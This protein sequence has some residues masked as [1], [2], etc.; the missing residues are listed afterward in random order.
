MT[1]KR[2][3][4]SI[5]AAVLVVAA[6][7]AGV[8]LYQNNDTSSDG[9]ASATQTASDTQMLNQ[10]AVSRGRYVAIMSDCVACHTALGSNQPF[11]GGYPIQTP[12][13]TIVSSNITPDKDTGIGNWTE[14]QFFDAVRH[15]QSP[16]GYLYPAMPYT[17]Y[18]KLT[19]QDMQDLW[20]YMRSVRPVHNQVAPNQ[21]PFPYNIRLMML[22]WNLLFF[23][24][25]PFKVDPTQSAQ[26]VRGQY[27]VD[28]AEHCI[29]C[30]TSKNMLGGDIQS[31]YLQGDELQGWYAPE[32]AGNDH[33]GLGGWSTQGIV[34]YLK[35]GSN[36]VS[37]ASGPMAEVVHNSTQYLN[38]K[39]LNAIAVYLKSVKGSATPAR[40]RSDDQTVAAMMGWGQH[41]FEAN[42]SACHNV[43]GQGVPGMVTAFA[44]NPSVQ[45]N[46][47][48]SL[49]QTV[50]AGG[51]A[52]ITDTNPT[53]AGMPSFAWKMSDHDIAAV[54]TYVRNSWGNQAPAVTDQQVADTRKS[55]KAPTPFTQAAR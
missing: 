53:G 16:H 19:D 46:N 50:L 4:L 20:A 44:H 22:G 30:H 24:N 9:V 11:A 23:S 14:R 43:Q 49:I 7:G 40:S 37:V 41:L 15:G 13:G 21:M 45:S 35:T 42:C 10:A 27:L 2:L 51:R 25:T 29:A 3:A 32:I 31:Q 26:W 52:A 38:D 34:D 17:S 5:A 12:F 48:A 54:L 47:P 33:V 55:L 39:D 28:G 1:K 8:A 18:L 6:V 36:Q